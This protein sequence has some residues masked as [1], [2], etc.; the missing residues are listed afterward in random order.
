MPN[1]EPCLN[2]GKAPRPR[3]WLDAVT[4]ASL[5]AELTEARAA[6]VQAAAVS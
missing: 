5:I 3:R 2:V 6:L 4:E 1:G